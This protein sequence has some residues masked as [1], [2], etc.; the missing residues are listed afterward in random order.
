MV[1]VSQ[2][3]GKKDLWEKL[4]ECMLIKKMIEKLRGF[5]VCVCVCVKMHQCME[6]GEVFNENPVIYCNVCHTRNCYLWKTLHENS[7][8]LN[9]RNLELFFLL[10]K[11]RSWRICLSKNDFIIFENILTRYLKEIMWILLNI[12]TETIAAQPIH[13]L[14]CPCVC[15]SVCV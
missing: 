15:V 12:T 13:G 2:K 4:K 11:C 6:V 7:R 3:G 5:C 1:S 8:M 10:S 9:V 14:D